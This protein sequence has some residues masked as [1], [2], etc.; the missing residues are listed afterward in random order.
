MRTIEVSSRA[1]VRMMELTYTDGTLTMAR[2]ELCGLS[3]SMCP[4][5][6]FSLKINVN[7]NKYIKTH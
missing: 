4:A 7:D 3:S 5:L 1:S 2:S 6:T